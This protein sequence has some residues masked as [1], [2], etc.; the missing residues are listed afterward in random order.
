LPVAGA[1]VV[2]FA[3][4]G[5]P[6]NSALTDA[7]GAFSMHSLLSG[8]YTLQIYNTY[9]NAAGA[10]YASTGATSGSV[11]SGPGILVDPGLPTFAGTIT[12]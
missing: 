8:A 4:D 1:T 5:T 9:T 7:S 3:E 11:V 6:G 12:D 2:A 10:N